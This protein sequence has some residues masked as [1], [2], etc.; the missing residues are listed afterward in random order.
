[1]TDSGPGH[2]VA[3]VFHHMYVANG[4]RFHFSETLAELLGMDI[5][6]LRALYDLPAPDPRSPDFD[7]RVQ[8]ISANLGCAPDIL[9]HLLRHWMPV[10]EGSGDG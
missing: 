9:A 4:E 6:N 10:G 3:G 5:A 1:M 8:A 2:T 7:D